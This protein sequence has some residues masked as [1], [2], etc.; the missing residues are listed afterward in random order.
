MGAAELS[1]SD[2]VLKDLDQVNRLH[3]MPF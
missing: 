2:E 3:P 1:L